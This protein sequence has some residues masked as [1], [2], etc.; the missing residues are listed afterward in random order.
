LDTI[1]EQDEDNGDEESKGGVAASDTAS[2]HS[3]MSQEFLR[4][5]KFDKLRVSVARNEPKEVNI[6]SPFT[7]G[8]AFPE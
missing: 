6:W 8:T 7:V 2:V 5:Q 1:L 3:I 4:V